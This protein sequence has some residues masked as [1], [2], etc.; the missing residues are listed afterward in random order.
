VAAARSFEAEA[1]PTALDFDAAGSRIAAGFP[2]GLLRILST[3]GR[4]LASSPSGEPP[5]VSIAFSG[6]GRRIVAGSGKS[7][8]VVDAASGASLASWPAGAQDVVAV[9]CSR[10]GSVVASASDDP[11]M[12]L[13]KADGS[14]LSTP[15][16]GPEVL[17]IAF[18]P[19]GDVA[20]GSSDTK[21]RLFSAKAG[22]LRR[23]LELPMA[24]SVLAFSPDRRWLAAGSMDGSVSLFD[25][26]SGE[27]KGILGRHALPAG[28]AAFSPDGKRLACASVSTNPW[29]AEAELKVWDLATRK[30]TTASIGVALLAAIGFSASGAPLAVVSRDRTFSLWAF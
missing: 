5:V 9:A 3:S 2:G 12:K 13:W 29:G 16:A 8:R 24:C 18:S 7:V 27:S 20:A 30:E 4:P 28:A 22:T 26:N 17:G 1:R 10:D 25:A 23:A 15:D 11:P 6:D 14:P 19:S 21:V